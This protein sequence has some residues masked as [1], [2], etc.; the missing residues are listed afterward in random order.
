[1]K[2]SIDKFEIEFNGLLKRYYDDEKLS[3][4]N[5]DINPPKEVSD[6]ITGMINDFYINQLQ[7]EI[8]N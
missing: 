6:R 4:L 1:M 5:Q 3:R 7:I 8:W 2:T